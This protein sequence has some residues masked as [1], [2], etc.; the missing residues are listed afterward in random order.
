MRIKPVHYSFPSAFYFGFCFKL[1]ILSSCLGLMSSQLLWL[2][3]QDLY[4]IKPDKFQHRWGRGSWN[5][6]PNWGAIGHLWLMWEEE[7]VQECDLSMVTYAPVNGP[8]LIHVQTVRNGFHELKK[9][10]CWEGKVFGEIG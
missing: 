3:S 2:H 4:K 10:W 9:K 8:K 1:L 7:A 6:T 5:P